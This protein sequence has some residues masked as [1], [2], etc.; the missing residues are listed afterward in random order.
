MDAWAH[1]RGHISHIRAQRH[2][3]ILKIIILNCTS[4]AKQ[5]IVLVL[6]GLNR[7]PADRLVESDLD[8]GNQVSRVE[9]WVSEQACAFLYGL[10]ICI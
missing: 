5:L 4:A 3:L 1:L 6:D 8:E 9:I 2:L 7:R 10:S